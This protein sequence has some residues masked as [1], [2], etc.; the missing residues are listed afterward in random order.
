[1]IYIAF[2]E[3]T[4]TTE[5]TTNGPVITTH[6]PSSTSTTITV[7][8][9]NNTVYAGQNIT[10]SVIVNG[11]IGEVCW[12]KTQGDLAVKLEMALSLTKAS[13][14]TINNPS[15]TLYNVSAHDE[16]VYTCVVRY[17]ADTVKSETITLKVLDRK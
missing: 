13:G 5:K 11:P 17:E 3:V 14:A 10:L 8:Q 15:L 2:L 9:R 4:V 16:A 6:S 7:V 12:E 1:M